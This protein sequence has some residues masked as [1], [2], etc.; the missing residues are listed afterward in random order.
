MNTLQET[1]QPGNK[2]KKKP[3]PREPGPPPGRSA[4]GT[5]N[6]RPKSKRKR[7]VREKKYILLP[8]A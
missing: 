1:G 5:L 4:P 8:Q 7:P 2:K 6:K 3:I